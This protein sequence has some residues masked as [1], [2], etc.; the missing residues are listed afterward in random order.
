MGRVEVHAL[1]RAGEATRDDP[2]TEEAAAEASRA[3]G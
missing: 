1:H 2:F 3:A